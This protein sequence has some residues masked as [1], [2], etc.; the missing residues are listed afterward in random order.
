MEVDHRFQTE[1]DLEANS[2]VDS[3][4][5]EK[6]GALYQIK[7]TREMLI[8]RAFLAEW[9]NQLKAAGNR[10]YYSELLAD[11]DRKSAEVQKLRDAAARIRSINNQ[12]Q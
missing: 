2:K 12:N 6:A 11:E 1:A 4:S 8:K 5:L 10:K 3:K 9:S 7:A